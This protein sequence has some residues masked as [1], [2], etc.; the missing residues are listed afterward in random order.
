M[1]ILLKSKIVLL[2]SIFTIGVYASENSFRGISLCGQTLQVGDEPHQKFVKGRVVDRNT[3]E[4]L[5]GVNV[6]VKGNAT[7]TATDIDGYYSLTVPSE[8]SVLL[9]SYIGYE[10]QE[11][12]LKGKRSLDALNV[13]MESDAT[14]LEEVVIYTGYM[15]QK[16]GFDR[17]GFGSKCQRYQNNFIE[18]F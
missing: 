10:K 12:L 15:S 1:K 17:C 4:A 2:T 5:I 13:E 11:I 16:S 8:S 7:G 18:C 3:G 6:I 14:M 9:F